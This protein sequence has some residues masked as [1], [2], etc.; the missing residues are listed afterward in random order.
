MLPGSSAVEVER[1]VL[2]VF[3]WVTVPVSDTAASPEMTIFWDLE[4]C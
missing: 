3:S 4:F 2:L 1:G